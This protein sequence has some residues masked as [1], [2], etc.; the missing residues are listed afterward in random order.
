[1]A[2]VR[3]STPVAA[4]VAAIVVVPVLVAQVTE[5]E[6]PPAAKPTEAS[7]AVTL[8]DSET[9]G[10]SD[11]L[12]R[13]MA[14]GPPPTEAT[15]LVSSNGLAEAD[16]DAG[17]SEAGSCGGLPVRRA[18]GAGAGQE[19]CLTVTGIEDGEQLS[20]KLA[21]AG[22]TL[23]LSVARGEPFVVLPLL[24]TLGGLIAGGIVSLLPSLLRNRVRS[25][26]LASALAQNAA[27]AATEKIEDLDTWVDDRHSAGDSDDSLLPVVTR[28]MK[29]GP[30]KARAARATLKRAI[31][32]SPL[33]GHD[34]LEA[35]RSE[36]ADR[37]THRT[38]DFLEGSEGKI[39]PASRWLPALHEL[40]RTAPKLDKLERDIK[41]LPPED[42]GE[43][44]KKLREARAAYD[45]ANEP[46]DPAELAG[47]LE[48]VEESTAA[49]RRKGEALGGSAFGITYLTVG[50][51]PEAFDLEAFREGPEPTTRPIPTVSDS[52][53]TAVRN[54]GSELGW[55]AGLTVLICVLIA[56]WAVLVIKET[57]YEP[58]PAFG[59]FSD[60]FALLVGSI[61]SGAAGAVVGMLGI[62]NPLR[63][64]DE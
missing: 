1:M 30:A 60:Y 56:V 49:Q 62:W 11:A 27:A 16:A 2:S 55:W 53:I 46:S 4:A 21:G 61:G 6:P 25:G 45:S 38:S 58:K 22:T 42:Q 41:L 9:S 13:I 36:E 52:P 28:T 26:L 43:P 10:D 18:V 34:F 14:A 32:A 15:T 3:A 31:E 8:E 29:D 48:A 50:A 64:T 54:A 19:W 63:P 51:G 47:K 23:T 44:G 20:G 59:S 17:N 37:P 57:L 40:E 33:Q 39:H 7:L 12:L 35:A 5:P 24:L